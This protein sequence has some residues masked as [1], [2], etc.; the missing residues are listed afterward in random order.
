MSSLHWNLEQECEVVHVKGALASEETEYFHLVFLVETK[1]WTVLPL[2]LPWLF[3]STSSLVYDLVSN[4]IHL[5]C[6]YSLVEI[7]DYNR[8]WKPRFLRIGDKINF[9]DRKSTRLNSSHLRASRMPSSAWKNQHGSFWRA[10]F[11][12]ILYPFE[13]EDTGTRWNQHWRNAPE[14]CLCRHLKSP[15]RNSSHLNLEQGCEVV[16]VKGALASEE[17]EY[18]HIVFLVETKNLNCPSFVVALIVLK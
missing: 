14:E 17:T 4:H 18:F 11:A 8:S 3:W 16:H 9:R 10:S 2:L 6:G 13:V 7:Q 5:Y 1:T 15:H 12:S